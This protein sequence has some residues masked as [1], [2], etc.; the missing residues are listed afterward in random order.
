MI[1]IRALSVSRGG[2]TIVKDITLTLPERQVISC[3]GPNGAGKSTL[4]AALGGTLPFRGKMLCKGKPVATHEI[5]YM[6][7]HCRVEAG[8]T[9][10]QVLLLGRH[11]ALG[12]RLRPADYA[13]AG[14]MLAA[15]GLSHLAERP[16]TT[17]SG[18]QQQLILLGQ[19]LMRKPRLLLLDEATSALDLSHQ[20]RVMQLLRSYVRQN[21]AVALIAIHDLTLAGRHSDQVVL[22][23]Q[24]TLVAQGRFE[25]AITETMLRQTYG[26]EARILTDVDDGPVIVPLTASQPFLLHT[27][28]P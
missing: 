22:L 10:L 1:D 25:T 12:L 23:H 4:L 16:M 19:R 17:L 2:K 20:M 27:Q 14:E 26:I 5:G 15:L 21:G 28:Q 9:A 3:I 11:E 24:G 18:G 7:Q 6:P 8:L 13:A